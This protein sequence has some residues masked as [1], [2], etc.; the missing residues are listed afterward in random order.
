[1]AKLLIKDQQ[2]FFDQVTLDKLN[3]TIT[4][5]SRFFNGQPVFVNYFNHRDTTIEPGLDDNLAAI[6][7]QS[8]NRFNK[9]ENL[10]VYDFP[11]LD[12]AEEL[13]DFGLEHKIEGSCVILADM[14]TPY[15][16]DFFHISSDAIPENYMFQITKVTRDKISN[17]PFFKVEF[18]LEHHVADEII[19]QIEEEFEVDY[20]LIG[21]QGFNAVLNKKNT[22]LIESLKD[23]FRI[24]FDFF[25]ETF[26]H[27]S[28]NIFRFDING[29]GSYY[30]SPDMEKFLTE[31]NLTTN[32]SI[33][34]Y[35]DDIYLDE[36][37]FIKKQK[38]YLLINIKK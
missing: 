34:E 21:K 23:K 12:I 11:E 5:Y 18:A 1:M 37:F 36:V 27:E 25:K 4:D 33:K 35:T 3:Q 2:T 26:Y 8:P 32:I 24:V 28:L 19:D 29:T 30:Y 22:K 38:N 10:P 15:E 6:G 7:N 20:D 9:I 13:G 14:I 31:F 17:Q 16:E